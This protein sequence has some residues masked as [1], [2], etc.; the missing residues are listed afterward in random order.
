MVNLVLAR[1]VRSDPVLD[2][3]RTGQ[4][5]A[6]R[7]PKLRASP[8]DRLK[9]VRWCKPK[10]DR[11]KL[12]ARKATESSTE[13][14]IPGDAP[15]TR[16]SAHLSSIPSVDLRRAPRRS[17]VGGPHRRNPRRGA[18]ETN[19]YR[20]YVPAKRVLFRPPATVSSR[21][22]PVAPADQGAREARRGPRRDSRE[23]SL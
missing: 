8:H 16:Q 12:A 22:R 2:I 6:P 23:R 10:Q 15:V 9:Q 18:R 20:Q 19:E 3:L 13:A 17:S 4:T 1:P 14:G 5:E 11:E 7:R 21:H